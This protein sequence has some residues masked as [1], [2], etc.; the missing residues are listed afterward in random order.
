[1]CINTLFSCS[2]CQ[3]I[4]NLN[5]QIAP[6]YRERERVSLSLPYKAPRTQACFAHLDNGSCTRCFVD[7]CTDAPVN[8]V[9]RTWRNL[10]YIYLV[11]VRVQNSSDWCTASR[12]PVGATP[13]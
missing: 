5:N 13:R 7:A 10:S 6:P 8:I 2:L 11:F 12:L 9:V 3:T 4:R 1:M